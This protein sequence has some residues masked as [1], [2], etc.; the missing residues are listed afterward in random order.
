NVSADLRVQ[1]DLS[2]PQINGSVAFEE[3]QLTVNYLK[4][5]Y[6]LN[7]EVEVKNSVISIDDL[8]LEDIDGNEAIANGTVDLNDIDNP[9]IQV[10]LSAKNFMALNTTSKDNAVYFGKAYATGDFDFRGPT[11]N[12]F[13]RI[14]AKTEKG[15]IF[16]LPLNSTETVSEKDFITFVSKDTTQV[17]KRRNNFDGLRMNFKLKVDPNSVAN[18][19]TVLGKLSGKGNAELDLNISSAGDFEMKGDYI[20]E[21]GNFDFTAQEVIN[22]RFDIRQGGTIRW[23][24]NPAN[25]QINLKAI[26]AV[27]A[28][29]RDL[30]TAANSDNSSS[31]R[32][33][34]EVEM[35]LSG[36][37]L[38]PDIK[39][40]I[41]FPANPAVKEEL[42]AY[43]N[44]GNNLNKQALSL[45]IQRR[46]APG[47]GGKE[48]LAQQ[49]GSVGTS[50]ATEL[51]FNQLNNLL[52]SMNLN[53]VDVNIRSF[54]E[55][56]ASFRFFNDRVVANLGIVDRASEN[57]FS[58]I[59]FNKDNVGREVEIL[60][61]IRKDGTL[62]GKLANKPPTQ[63]SVFANPGVNQNLNVTSLGLIYNQQFDTFKE[64]LQ[65]ISGKYR[66][67]Q[68]K[69]EAE[70][71][72]ER[73][74]KE[75]LMNESKKN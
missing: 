4:T 71:Q 21:T 50:T 34:T 23:T 51:I 53:F 67:D 46:F 9:N 48:N 5:S 54:N 42:Q 56:S 49:L 38:Q 72:K 44:D 36:L 37:L 69:K 74:T 73:L 40:D 16:N 6:K 65:K 14:D 12:M 58:P 32:V 25:A 29:L 52:S 60:G 19:Y 64:F 2:K 1:G 18:I 63:Q 35:G 8:T 27:R 15:T 57:D 47:S 13:I 75:A 66:R 17:V 70:A 26:Y 22:K 3:G 68:K 24:G 30:Y 55:A 41:F 20:I 11:N 45:I 62:I 33:P 39:L 28:S 31:Q 10:S 7:D 43:F 61:L 59:G